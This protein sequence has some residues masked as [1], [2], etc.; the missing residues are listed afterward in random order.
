MEA[1]QGFPDVHVADVKA[2]VDSIKEV[3]LLHI[4]LLGAWLTDAMLTLHAGQWQRRQGDRPAAGRDND[5][6]WPLL[7]PCDAN[8]VGPLPCALV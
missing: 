6:W 5:T 4:V 7:V 8:I 1:L 2:S 3:G